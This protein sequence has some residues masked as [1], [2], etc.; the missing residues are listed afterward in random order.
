[1]EPNLPDTISCN[2]QLTTSS[3]EFIFFVLSTQMRRIYFSKN[4]LK[5]RVS[6]NR[7]VYFPLF[8]NIHY[9]IVSQNWSM[10]EQFLNFT[11][12]F[13]R[14]NYISVTTLEFWKY[15]PFFI[16]TILKRKR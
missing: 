10:A 4:L 12:H 1:M 15:F 2:N 8:G 11:K 9:G 5:Y 3:V 14:K 7:G 6:K 13:D 16:Q